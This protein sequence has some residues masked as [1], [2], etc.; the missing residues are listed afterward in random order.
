MMLGSGTDRETQRSPDVRRRSAA[1]LPQQIAS[2]PVALV[3]ALLL[4]VGMG[5]LAFV[6]KVLDLGNGAILVV[7]FLGPLVAY[8]ILTGQ[9]TEFG[10]G[11]VNLKFREAARTAVDA[12]VQLVIAE[13]T[14]TIKKLGSEEMVRIHAL[15]PEAP[16]VLTLTLGPREGE[17]VF[18]VLRQYLSELRRHPRFRFVVF[19]DHDGRVVG[20]LSS[21]VLDR[22]L[23]THTTAKPFLEAVNAGRLPRD[24]SVRTEF[25]AADTTIE[26]ALARMTSLQLEAM[27]VRDDERKLK[28]VVEREDVLARLLLAAA[29]S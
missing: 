27:L 16:V 1:R 19:L 24:R 18:D 29:R 15:D 22:Q 9:L 3:G 2:Y 13:E 25:L 14:Q 17:Y 7:A 12:A 8:L 28:G 23:E 21:Y 5:L 11:G 20:Y 6:A 26:E 4:A 10:A